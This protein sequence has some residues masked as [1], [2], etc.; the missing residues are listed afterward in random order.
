[1]SQFSLSLRHR[2]ASVVLWIAF[3]T[4]TVLGNLLD[5]VFG[6]FAAG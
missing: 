2:P 4:G 5:D 6:I 1:M 3:V